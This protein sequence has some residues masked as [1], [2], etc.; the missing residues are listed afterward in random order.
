ML[1]KWIVCTVPPSHRKVFSQAQE[2]WSIIADA[3]GF[4]GQI[5]GWNQHQKKQACILA[6][7]R[8]VAAYQNFMDNIHDTVTDNN[9]QE[10]TYSA[11]EVSLFDTILD[12]NGEYSNLTQSLAASVLRV[13]DCVVKPEK[14]SH[15]EQIQET[16]WNIGMAKA[17]GML[18]GAFNRH[19]NSHNHYLVTTLW[20]DIQAHEN[21]SKNHL[22]SLREKADVANDLLK[23]QGY[24]VELEPSWCILPE[25]K[26]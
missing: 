19:S 15:F 8:D 24:L 17:V 16:V 3:D 20:H 1:I 2:A 26:D 25:L 9:T 5:G 10:K 12:I 22:P 23:I 4:Y 11:I 13:A 6:L 18:G 7:W 21:Y 14:V